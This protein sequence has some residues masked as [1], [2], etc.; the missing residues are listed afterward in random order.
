M[1]SKPRPGWFEL[2]RQQRVPFMRHVAD[3]RRRVTGLDAAAARVL[4]FL[5]D[6]ITTA[7]H[8]RAFWSAVPAVLTRCDEQETYDLPMASEAYAWIH[9]LDRYVRTWYALEQM[10]HRA[11]FPLGKR[12][13]NVLDVG[14]GPGPSVPAIVDFYRELRR[15]AFLANEPRLDQPCT[16]TAVELSWSNNQFR[17]HFYEATEY[18]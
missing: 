16:V 18:P 2:L 5:A 1:R 3:N 10:F 8:A 11:C 14:T 7:A 15:Y 9:L 12:G 17:E 4:A 6:R 13:V